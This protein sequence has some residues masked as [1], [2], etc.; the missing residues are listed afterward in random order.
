M[1]SA[2]RPL[3]R[4]RRDLILE[5]VA[6]QGSVRVSELTDRLGVSDMTVRRD[7]DALASE[8]VVRKVHG[9]ATLPGDARATVGEPGFAAKLTEQEDE[10][11]GIAL[12]AAALVQPGTAIGL[13]AGTTTWR[14]ARELG[15]VADLVVVT[16]SMRI[17]ETLLAFERPDQ[18]VMLTGGV[19]TPSDA[20]VG[21][22]AEQ[23]LRSLHLDQV[24]MG[25]HGMTERAGFTTPNLMEVETNRV[26]VAAAER[27]VV[28]AD[29]TKWGTVGLATI[30]PLSA[31]DVVVTDAAIPTGAAEALTAAGADIVRAATTPA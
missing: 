13:T 22:L 17:C 11:A 5:L 27:L 1:T 16:N 31:A 24:F 7:L 18:T 28:I 9:G 19:R 26:F 25:V 30:A 15:G 23:S 14:L 12:A 3:A 20:L 2:S 10:K 29:H 6:N 8:G 4:R 21:P